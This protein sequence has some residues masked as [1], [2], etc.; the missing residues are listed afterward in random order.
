VLAGVLLMGGSITLVAASARGFRWA[1][2]LLIVFSVVDQSYYSLSYIRRA[3]TMTLERYGNLIPMPPDGDKWRVQLWNWDDINLYKNLRSANGYTPLKP[4]RHLDY[5]HPGVRRLAGVGWV[6]HGSFNLFTSERDL[7]WVPSPDPLPYVRLIGRTVTSKRPERAVKQIDVAT[8]AV[9]A[10]PLE[11]PPGQ[12][13]T[14]VLESDRSGHLT[15]RTSAP[16]KRLLVVAESFHPG[17][18]AFV[19]GRGVRPMTVY[20]DFIGCIVPAGAHRVELVFQPWSLEVG[21]WGTVGALA[22]AAG[23]WLVA[24]YLLSCKLRSG[25]SRSLVSGS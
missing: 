4:R 8:T 18:R 12:P 7:T 21:R 24:G 11:L 9:V 20:G 6:A 19:D 1:L 25:A 14:A 13:G 3:P 22:A 17:W 2:P 15:M 5:D 10:E 23:I 16:A